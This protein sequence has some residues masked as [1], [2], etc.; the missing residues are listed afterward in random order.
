MT[1]ANMRTMAANVIA[2]RA[3]ER[4]SE[5]DPQAVKS[6]R[7]SPPPRRGRAWINGREVG[8]PDPRFAHLAATHD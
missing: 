7:R 2:L 4:R 1:A 3:G 8:G 6:S 5:A